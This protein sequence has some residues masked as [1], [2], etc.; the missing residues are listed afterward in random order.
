MGNPEIPLQQDMFTGSLVDKRTPAQK[1]A[2]RQRSLP[3][4]TM[5]FSQREIAQFG[6][7]ARPLFSLSPHMKLPLLTYDPRT[8][9]EIEQDQQQAAEDHTAPLF[10]D[11]PVETSS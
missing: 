8:E 4:Q 1:R 11:P 6:V 2:D 7:K 10:P 5:L 9:A 3:Q